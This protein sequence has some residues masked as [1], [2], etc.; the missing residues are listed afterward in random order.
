MRPAKHALSPG[1]CESTA[2]TFSRPTQ[3]MC[4]MKALEGFL[5][6]ERLEASGGAGRALTWFGVCVWFAH[7]VFS[8]QCLVLGVVW[9]AFFV[10]CFVFCVACAV[11][12]VVCCVVCISCVVLF[13][14]DSHWPR[15]R[16]TQAGSQN[17]YFDFSRK[18]LQTQYC[19]RPS[20]CDPPVRAGEIVD[21]T[22]V[23]A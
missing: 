10:I 4:L 14:L 12:C 21:M 11:S 8:A 19:S 2:Q 5:A 1:N 6:S 18:P 17:G 3:A 20:F 22:H 15:T 7:S 9:F 23:F 16:I 13:R